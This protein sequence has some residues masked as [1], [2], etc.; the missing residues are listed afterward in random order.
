VSG[1]P[2]AIAG[3]HATVFL[4]QT[5]QKSRKSKLIGVDNAVKK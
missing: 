1:T 2:A 5:S 4:F 3:F